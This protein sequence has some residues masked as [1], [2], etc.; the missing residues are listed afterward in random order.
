[1]RFHFTFDIIF[2]NNLYLYLGKSNISWECD[3]DDV[4]FELKRKMLA[5]FF[6]KE[7]PELCQKKEGGGNQWEWKN[8]FIYCAGLQKEMVGIRN[9]LSEFFKRGVE[10]K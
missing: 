3:V 6:K 2:Y 5:T 9:I 1:M 8:A 4:T 7:T 10:V